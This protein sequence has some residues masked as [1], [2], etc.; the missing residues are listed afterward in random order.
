MSRKYQWYLGSLCLFGLAMI[1]AATW[2]YGA[3]V[4][5]DAVRNLS[6]VDSL[7]AGRGFVDLY[8]KPLTWWPPLYP[9]LIFGLSLLTNADSFVA[10]WY[11]NVVL[12]VLNIR[13]AGW[14]FW[15]A[16]REQ[17]IFAVGCALVFTLSRSML[18]LHAN[19]STDPLFIT[20]M[21]V[22]FWLAAGY[23]RNPSGRLRWAFF[24]LSGIAF[25]HRFPGI[26]F[27]AVSGLLIWYRE[28]FRS[29]LRTIPQAVA[30][31]LP[32]AAWAF[33][34]T[35]AQTGTFFGARRPELM[36]PLENVNNSLAR[37]VHWF[38]P[39][40]TPLA[41]VLLN[42]WIILVPLLLVLLVLNR[43][44]NWQ[45]LGRS[46]FGNMHVMPYLVFSVLY[47]VMMLFTVVTSDHLDVYS[48]RYYVILLPLVLVLGVYALKHLVF[49]HVDT[50]RSLVRYA[51]AAL[52]LL[53]LVYP[54]MSLQEYLSL[55]LEQGEASSYNIANTRAYRESQAI[56]LGRELLQADPGAMIYS[57][58][59]TVTWFAYRQPVDL[60]P[61]RDK[62]LSFSERIDYLK[63]T[64]PGWPNGRNGYLIWFK[65]NQY[66]HIPFPVE[67]ELVARLELIYEDNK[68][69]VYRVSTP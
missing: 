24:L 42:P 30:G 54:L 59:P 6:T 14:F 28:G 64:Y 29:A 52:F 15:A 19:V 16:F 39:L 27:F 68:G 1:V 11:L 63:K 26:V 43:R 34:F 61:S 9:Y 62:K 40:L 25:L 20:M 17:P 53:W 35:Y 60:L 56:T 13:L 23:L 49:S 65:P 67:L 44:G 8:G 45:A 5:S 47:Y 31:I 3:G 38:I 37:M 48:D 41:Q 21:F 7:L 32:S 69:A 66:H 46:V 2:R 55:S 57:N 33:F 10:A 18:S 12:Y 36:L 58:Y 4:S 51:G 22:Y 50:T